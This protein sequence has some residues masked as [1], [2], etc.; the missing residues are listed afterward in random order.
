M[1]LV[2]LE[3][4]LSSETTLR[5]SGLLFTSCSKSQKLFQI[6]QQGEGTACFPSSFFFCTKI[7]LPSV[8][9]V[10]ALSLQFPFNVCVYRVEDNDGE[11]LLIE[12][13]DYLPKWLNPDTSENRVSH[14]NQTI[15]MMMF[16]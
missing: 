7:S 14:S 15:D 10:F 16:F 11:F 13:A 3:A 12:A 1:Y 5:T 8:M 6:L 2:T 4:A 9:S